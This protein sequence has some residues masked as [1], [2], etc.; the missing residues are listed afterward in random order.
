MN[1][2]RVNRFEKIVSKLIGNTIDYSLE[3]RFFTAACFV[4]ATAGLFAT[5]INIAFS[6]EPSLILTTIGVTILYYL[7]YFVSIKKKKFKGLIL[8]YVLI[9]LITISYI[10][11]VNA[12]SNGPVSYILVTALLVYIVITKGYFRIVVIAM[13]TIALTLLFILEFKYPELIVNYSDAKSKFYDLYLTALFCVGL[14]TFITSYIMSNYQE[15]R[16]KE[17]K[18][19]DT[20]LEQN[21]EILL[22]GKELRK[23]KEFTESIIS[24]AQD[25]IIVLDLKYNF[26]QANNAFLKMTGFPET[27]IIGLNFNDLIICPIENVDPITGKFSLPQVGTHSD[28][29]LKCNK[30]EMVPITISTAY[31]NDES[32]KPES[33]MAIIKDITD[34]KNIL[35]ELTL[36]KEHFEE[37]VDQ[38]TKELAET[39]NMLLAAKEKAETSDKLK[40]AFLSNM[41]HEIRTPMNAIIGFSQL[42]REPDLPRQTV[43]NYLDIVTAKGNLLMNI[44]NDIIDISRVEAGEMEINKS[45]FS[46]ND[47]LDELFATFNKLKESV[48]K[49]HLDLR[50]IKPEGDQQFLIFTDPYR[51]KQILSNLLDNAIKFTHHGF[52]QVGYSFTGEGKNKKIK[53][54]VRDSGIGILP[55]N[56]DIIFNRFRQ[57]DESHTR[58]FGGTG[59]GLTISKKLTMLLGGE[60]EVDSVFGQGSMFYLSIPYKSVTNKEKGIKKVQSLIRDFNWK[61]KTILIVEDNYSSYLLLKYYLMN[62]GAQILHTISGKDAIEICKSNPHID[63][64]LMDIQLPDLSGYETTMIIKKHR[65]DLP[66]IAQTAYAMAGDYDKSKDAGCD[67]YIAKPFG[68]DKLLAVLNEYLN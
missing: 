24:S 39:N 46:V 21:R 37:L 49:S 2:I 14:I 31:L 56:K 1:Y 4:G 66:V 61:E 35:H 5:I 7:F 62:T 36:H 60:L 38:R 27:S 15:E 20:I 22:A 6:L 17:I 3:H 32:G 64:V 43:M 13:V 45:S 30:G 23:S 53:F 40:S 63:V 47:M 42:L 25:G 48:N 52:I 8:P 54:Y 44:I 19:R 58:E 68:K 26:L 16:E 9:S 18:Q 50:V 59:L 41:S 28:C 57:V 12:G 10:W 67:D 29:I 51:L 33:I 65:S 55:E 11:F 34:Y